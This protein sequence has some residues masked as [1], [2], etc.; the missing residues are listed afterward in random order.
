MEN[1]RTELSSNEKLALSIT[2]MEGEGQ[3]FVLNGEAADKT[4]LRKTRKV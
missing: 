4:L 3:H 1:L 2:G